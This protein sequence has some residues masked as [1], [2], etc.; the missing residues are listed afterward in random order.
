MMRI[1]DGNKIQF[2]FTFRILRRNGSFLTFKSLSTLPSY[3]VLVRN[4]VGCAVRMKSSRLVVKPIRSDDGV[5]HDLSCSRVPT[6]AGPS[7]A[8]R[9]GARYFRVVQKIV[10]AT[11]GSGRARFDKR[12]VVVSFN[13][14][15]YLR[16]RRRRRVIAEPK[17]SVSARPFNRIY[18]YISVGNS[19][20]RDNSSA[21]GTSRVNLYIH[22][23]IYITYIYVCTYRDR[24]VPRGPLSHT[25]IYICIYVFTFPARLPWRETI[26]FDNWNFSAARIPTYTVTC[27]RI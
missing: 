20:R 3:Q 1:H 7:T 6:V 26:C 24:S 14:D 23:Y 4:N 19:R 10:G 5:G 17:E 21:W 22:T 16:R 12:V 2:N 13:N 8:G 27:L 9:D 25:F 11:W 18:Y 15:A